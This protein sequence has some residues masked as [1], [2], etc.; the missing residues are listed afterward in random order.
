MGTNNMGCSEKEGFILS[1]SNTASEVV[2]LN[3]TEVQEDMQQDQISALED[4]PEG[5]YHA[6]SA[7]VGG[8]VHI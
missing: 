7:V 5:G 2:K 6:W 8:S 4:F 3:N 1:M